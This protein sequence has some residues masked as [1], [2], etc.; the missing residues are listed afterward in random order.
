MEQHIANVAKSAIS[1]LA[2][3]INDAH[4]HAT[5]AAQA[6][7]EHAINAGNLLLQAKAHVK[8]GAWLTWMKEN[9]EVSERTAQAYMRLAREYPKLETSKAQRLR[10]CR[11][12]KL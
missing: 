10:I 9:C 7:V 12:G 8:H 1:E 2:A 11:C 3:Q 4:R 6:A 5:Q